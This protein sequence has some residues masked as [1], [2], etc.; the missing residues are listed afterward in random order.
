MPNVEVFIP[1]APANTAALGKGVDG[2]RRDKDLLEEAAERPQCYGVWVPRPLLP[3][4]GILDP[5]RGAK[6]GLAATDRVFAL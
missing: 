3:T 1:L 4:D 5:W 2:S 6:Q